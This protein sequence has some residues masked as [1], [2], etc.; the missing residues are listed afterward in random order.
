MQLRDLVDAAHL[1]I[2]PL[3]LPDGALDREVSWAFTTDLPDPSRYLTRGQLVLSG[4]VWRHS[5]TD[6]EPFVAVIAT[7]G[8]V[9]LL[10]G[11]GLFGQVPPDVVDACARHG[12]PLLAVPP[13]VS[14]A[15]ITSYI[16][17]ALASGRMQRLTA[18]LVR[19]R[20]LLME[21]YR[22]QLL[23]ELIGNTA[24]ELGRPVWVISATGRH[25]VDPVTALSESDLDIVTAA[26]LTATQVPVVV[27]VSRDRKLSVFVVSAVGEHRATAWFLLVDGD[28]TGWDATLLDSVQELA[29][30]TGLYRVQRATESALAD[31][32][33]ELL[34]AD[35]NQPETAVY[36]RQAGV[37][38]DD[39]AIVVAACFR[40]R[41]DCR[42]LALSIVADA[43]AHAGAP[44][45][46]TDG[47]ERV[48]AI[49]LAGDSWP[50]IAKALDRATA[51]LSEVL[52]VGVS[53]PARG[54]QLGG[55]LRAARFALLLDGT[56]AGESVSVVD[57]S[58]VGSA[59]QLLSAV[60]DD[61]RRVFVDRVLGTLI[62]HDSRYQSQLLP[63]L[64]AYLDC[65]GS[66]VR[67]AEITHLHLNSVRYR[68]ARV[69]KLTGRDLNTT[70]DRADLHL[71]LNL[72]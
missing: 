59:V 12:L 61:L 22:G 8:A 20:D 53:H 58:Q 57:G 19:Q 70:A 18:R 47:D 24:S 66:W 72:L 11:E 28:W 6:S 50:V 17:N 38:P 5:P 7:S 40:G 56:A 46:G 49:V 10:A 33:I 36:L 48:I 25:I 2:T 39:A 65:G 43:V 15:L 31:R 9:A 16:S 29:A 52:R 26:A 30:V 64:R 42:E 4:L 54:D 44:M 55:A 34:S 37:G 23:D 32:L 21:V 67:T 41:P 27:A 69:E 62:E 1:G 63:T 68:M 35:A 14:F 13:N 60:P 45:V 3:Y 71:A 51:G